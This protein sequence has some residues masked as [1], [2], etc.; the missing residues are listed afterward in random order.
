MQLP[1]SRRRSPPRRRRACRAPGRGGRGP[2]RH[3][4][5]QC[6]GPAMN[7]A[8]SGPEKQIDW[9]AVRARLARAL[10]ATEGAQALSPE[11]ARAVME[12]RTRDLARVPSEAER[13]T[14][15]LEVVC[16]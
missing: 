10:A 7:S 15:L 6:G 9:E 3:P 2:A 5:C 4:G 11:R 1:T 12:A 8:P 16:F 14:E 13:Y